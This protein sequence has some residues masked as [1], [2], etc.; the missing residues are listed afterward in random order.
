MEKD[1]E[2]VEQETAAETIESVTG[3]TAQAAETAAAGDSEQDLGLLL[4][5]ARS[6]A[7]EHWD[8]LMRARA[9]LDNLRKRQERE[10]ENAH[11]YALERFVNDLLPVRDSMELGV[12]AAREENGDI[13]KL[14]EGAELTLKLFTDVMQ[15]Y[16][17][18]QINPEGEPFNPEFHQAMSL[19]PRDDLPPNTVVTVV[20]KGYSLNGRLVRPAMVLVSRA[21]EQ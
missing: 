17:V 12:D 7:D 5:D 3:E 20:Q 21:A 13:G 15:K 1:Q 18:E 4:E 2:A 14:L 9:E 11:K 6:K 19:Q 10:L 16:N 8:Q